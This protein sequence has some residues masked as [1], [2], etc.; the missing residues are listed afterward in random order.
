MRWRLEGRRGEAS[1]IIW[2]EVRVRKARCLSSPALSNYS[3]Y[4]SMLIAAFIAQNSEFIYLFRLG[5]RIYTFVSTF[6]TILYALQ[7]REH[8]ENSYCI[9]ITK[10]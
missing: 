9:W 1:K 10:F 2:R 8:S 6:L 7:L 3:G 5:S 4:F